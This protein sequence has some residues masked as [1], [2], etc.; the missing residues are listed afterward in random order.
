MKL[1]LILITLVITLP[2]LAFGRI[3]KNEVQEELL[4]LEKESRRRLLK[5]TRKQSNESLPMTGL[6]LTRMGA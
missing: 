1:T 6:S 3:R 4:K 5:M 2:S